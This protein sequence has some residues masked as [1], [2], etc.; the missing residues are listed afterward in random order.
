MR[1]V[2]K[3]T[4]Y[5]HQVRALKRALKHGSLG[6]LWEPGTGKSKFVVDWTAALTLTEG[7]QRVL[8]ICPLSVVGVWEDEYEAHCPFPYVLNTLGPKDREVDWGSTDD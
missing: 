3:T 4:P 1:Y 8:I 6:V 2:F 7:P 5:K